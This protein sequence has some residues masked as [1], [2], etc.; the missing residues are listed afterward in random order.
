MSTECAGGSLRL[1]AAAATRFA[2]LG[3]ASNAHPRSIDAC[4]AV[5]ADSEARA[6]DDAAKTMIRGMAWTE[7]AM[8]FIAQTG[9]A[10]ISGVLSPATPSRV[11]G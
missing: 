11:S 2:T 3:N 1:P 6:N 10:S 5:R 9:S 4:M 8:G 7:K